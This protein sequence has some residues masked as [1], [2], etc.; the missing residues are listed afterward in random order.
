MTSYHYHNFDDEHFQSFRVWELK[1]WI[2]FGQWP[3]RLLDAIAK[4]VNKKFQIFAKLL[5]TIY[6]FFNFYF[7]FY[8]I[9]GLHGLI[10]T[11]SYIYINI[12]IDGP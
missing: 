12:Y 2:P 8:V 1:K 3:F 7:I 6:F 11:V 5:L 10:Y 4:N 9:N